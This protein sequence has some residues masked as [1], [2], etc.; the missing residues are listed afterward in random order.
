MAHK[1]Q[2]NGE[3]HTS[4]VSKGRRRHTCVNNPV[5]ITLESAYN[6]RLPVSKAKYQ[7]LQLLKRFCKIDNQAYFEEL[8][9]DINVKDDVV[10]VGNSIDD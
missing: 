6:N 4:V 10:T 9:H 1:D 7:D 2:W 8:P 5:Q 3:F